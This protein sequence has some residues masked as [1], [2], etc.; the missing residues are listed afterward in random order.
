MKLIPQGG[1]IYAHLFENPR[2]G[3][4][5]DLYWNISIDLEPVRLLGEEWDSSFQCEWLLWPVKVLTDLDGMGFDTLRHPALVEASLYLASEHHPVAVS[6]LEIRR[7]LG[8]RYRLDAGV[9]VDLMV[10]GARIAG[11]FH[12]Q[13]D[14]SFRGIV[15][16][17]ENLNPKPSNVVEVMGA[18]S[19]F[20][21]MLELQ[22]PRFEGFR[23]VLDANGE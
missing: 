17:P 23:Y 11:S 16:V 8:N 21:S 4:P 3:L 6:H 2:M 5:R 13:S 14:L 19:P 10:D 7:V 12:L 9:A 15:V 20:I 18:L 22:K 1:E